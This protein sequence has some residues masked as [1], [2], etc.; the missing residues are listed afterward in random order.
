MKVD[1]LIHARWIIPIEPTNTVYENHSIAIKDDKIEGILPSDD[2]RN[3]YSA[4]IEHHLD[5]HALIPGLIN[6]HTHS[7]MTLL[8]G[9]ANDLPLMEWLNEHIWPAEQKWV[10]SKFVKE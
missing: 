7:A 3:K 5:Q 2:A 6:A 4:M 10:N 8:R 9:L 1:T